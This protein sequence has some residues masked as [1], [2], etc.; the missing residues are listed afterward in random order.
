MSLKHRSRLQKEICSYAES[1]CLVA[2]ALYSSWFSLV[3]GIPCLYSVAGDGQASLDAVSGGAADSDAV[4]G[5][6]SSVPNRLTESEL[7]ASS[8]RYREERNVARKERSEAVE[9]NQ[10]LTAEIYHLRENR[11]ELLAEKQRL[12]TLT[13][14]L[15]EKNTEVRCASLLVYV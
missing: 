7:L 11:S 2:V 13:A 5:R 8:E 1:L 12:D 10:R 4:T 3:L 14:R 6:L 15:T 9:A